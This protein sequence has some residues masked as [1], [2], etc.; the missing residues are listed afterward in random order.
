[1]WCKIVVSVRIALGVRR[2]A[3]NDEN[4]TWSVIKAQLIELDLLSCTLTMDS[5]FRLRTKIGN[6]LNTTNLGLN[7]LN[8]FTL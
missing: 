6:I 3:E 5:D 8:I 2:L 7:Y 4:I 1:M